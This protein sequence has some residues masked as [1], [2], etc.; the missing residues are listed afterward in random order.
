M[1]LFF[2]EKDNERKVLAMLPEGRAW[3]QAWNKGSNFYKLVKWLAE[4]YRVI[5]QELNDVFKGLFLCESAKYVERMKVDYL[6]PDSV[7]YATN[8]AESMIDIFVL[9]FLANDNQNKGFQKI[10]NA[11]GIDVVIN[12]EAT[13]IRDSRIPNKV[14]HLL[15]GSVKSINDS[16]A[17]DFRIDESDARAVR[18]RDKIKKIYDFVKQAHTSIVYEAIQEPLP[19]RF[20]FCTEKYI[21]D[22]PETI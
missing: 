14:P 22:I 5:L 13:I 12:D 8:T 4:I 18:L 21:K 1:S 7:F 6:L 15:R 3:K 11:Y 20:V 19:T 2:N 9:Q 17:I 16:L 10:A